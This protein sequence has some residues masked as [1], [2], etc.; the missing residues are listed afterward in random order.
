MDANLRMHTAVFPP[1]SRSDHKL[2]HLEPCYYGR[3]VKSKPAT[4]GTVRRWL[5]EAYEALQGCF[6]ATDRQVLCAPHG[7]DV[8]GL[9]VYITDYINVC[10]GRT[11]P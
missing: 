1:L 9:T 7:E 3:L 5:E 8:D 10:V 6:V 4:T 2:I 11:V